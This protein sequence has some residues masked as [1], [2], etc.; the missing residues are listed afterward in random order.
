MGEGDGAIM[1]GMCL[2]QGDFGF[3]CFKAFQKVTD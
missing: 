1:G 2:H 3:E